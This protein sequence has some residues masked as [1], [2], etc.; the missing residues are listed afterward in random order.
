MARYKELS[1]IEAAEEDA[2]AMATM[3][4]KVHAELVASR[5]PEAAINGV[6]ERIAGAA[7]SNSDGHCRFPADLRDLASQPK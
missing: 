3:L 5:I 4:S 6:L 1:T 7:S 2:M